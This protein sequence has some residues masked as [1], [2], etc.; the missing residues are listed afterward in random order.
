MN[1]RITL[2]KVKYWF[3]TQRIPSKFSQS[4]KKFARPIFITRAPD[5]Q[6]LADL[7]DFKNEARYNKKYRYLLIVQDLF[8]R[9]ILALVPLRTKKS[10]EVTAVFLELFEKLGKKPKILNTGE[11]KKNY[12]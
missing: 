12:I 1:P 7:G 3:S 8:T 9:Q 4:K 2:K 10:K 6:W 11:I 5:I